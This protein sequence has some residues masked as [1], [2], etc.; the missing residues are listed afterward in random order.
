MR[1]KPSPIWFR[2]TNRSTVIGRSAEEDTFD[3][4]EIYF[5][6]DADGVVGGRFNVDRDVVFKK[7]ELLEAFGLLER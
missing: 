2:R 7:A 3:V 4:S 5:R 6:V 1:E